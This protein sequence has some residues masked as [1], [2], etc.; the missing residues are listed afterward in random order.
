MYNILRPQPANT[1]TTLANGQVLSA[2]T[3]NEAHKCMNALAGRGTRTAEIVG[4]RL[5]GRIVVPLG[6]VSKGFNNSYTIG[7]KSIAVPLWLPAGYDMI[8]MFFEVRLNPSIFHAPL[9]RW[10]GSEFIVE[11]VR[12]GIA[13]E[14]ARLDWRLMSN[15]VFPLQTGFF[16]MT[17]PITGLFQTSPIHTE[18]IFIRL[19][20]DMSEGVDDVLGMDTAGTLPNPTFWNGCSYFVAACY[21]NIVLC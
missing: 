21:K 9:N 3:I 5:N 14:V 13:W 18:E 1:L 10:L 15:V 6:V 7:R 12:G 4:S 2:S 19:T 20:F 16:K 17:T 11:F 8:D